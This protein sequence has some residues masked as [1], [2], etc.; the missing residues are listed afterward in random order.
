MPLP[1]GTRIDMELRYDNS[2]ENPHNPSSPPKRV[3]WG[4]QSLDEMG[5]VTVQVVAANQSDFP[6]LAKDAAPLPAAPAI[7]E[8]VLEQGSVALHP[9]HLGNGFDSPHAILKTA[10]VH[11]KLDGR[12]DL[13]PDGAR[14]QLHAGHQHHGFQS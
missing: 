11:Q 14:R 6:Q 5:S 12:G 9:G 1:K 13:L 4:E 8:H 10:D 7:D 2:A 3:K